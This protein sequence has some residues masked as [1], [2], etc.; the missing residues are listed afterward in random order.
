L[1]E[2]NVETEFVE[3]E[4]GAIEDELNCEIDSAAHNGNITKR[5]VAEQVAKA[6]LTLFGWN[7]VVGEC[8]VYLLCFKLVTFVKAG[9]AIEG[10]PKILEALLQSK[11]RSLFY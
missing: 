9:D 11:L 3:T 7:G 5:F 4:E 10:L 8:L 1:V 6:D 2:V